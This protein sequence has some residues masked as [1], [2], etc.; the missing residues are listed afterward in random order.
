MLVTGPG[1]YMAH[2]GPHSKVVGKER[3][4]RDGGSAF[5]GVE[6]GGLGF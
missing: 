1:N 3:G 2:M 6:G 4:S 5:I